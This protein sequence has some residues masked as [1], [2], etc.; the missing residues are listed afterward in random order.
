VRS[1]PPRSAVLMV[2][3][4]A[5]AVLASGCS[6][7]GSTASPVQHATYR[8]TCCRAADLA[9][10]HRPGHVLTLHWIA[11]TGDPSD[12]SP[13]PVTLHATLVGSFDTVTAAKAATT[14]RR[15]A[16]AQPVRTT[17]AAGGPPTSTI[18]IPADALAGFYNL[19]FAVSEGGGS[20]GGA[21]VIKVIG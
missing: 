4:A 12:Q 7:N 13:T 15:V 3:S 16:S 1:H 2:L 20:Y 11:T 5:F 17:D 21:A 10:P 8:Y 19:T 9:G 14:T 18:R 6:S